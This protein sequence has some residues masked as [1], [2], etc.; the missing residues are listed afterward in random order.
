MNFLKKLGVLALLMAFVTTQTIHANNFISKSSVHIQP[1]T[2]ITQLESSLSNFVDTLATTIFLS[3]SDIPLVGI[4][5]A[6]LINTIMNTTA[7]VQTLLQSLGGSTEVPI[8][9]LLNAYATEANQYA[10]GIGSL[11]EW[12]LAR[13]N[14]ALGLFNLSPLTLDF[15]QITN[16][17]DQLF[18]AQLSIVQND[19]D[20]EF[21]AANAANDQAH[22]IVSNLIDYLATRI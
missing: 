21:Q 17:V 7:T 10:S 9:N 3:T 16:L 13:D 18:Q 8:S 11:A 14:L 6:P 5:L 12:T 1:K 4:F 15:G 20:K 2:L 22:Q 19:L